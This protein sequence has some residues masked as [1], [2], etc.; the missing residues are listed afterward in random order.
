MQP[1]DVRKT[2]A[3]T[4]KLKNISNYKIFEDVVTGINRFVYWY[5]KKY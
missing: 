3:D 5:K 4:R 2:W 1:G